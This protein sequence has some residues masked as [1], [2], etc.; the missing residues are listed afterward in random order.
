[1]GAVRIDSHQHFWRYRASDYPWIGP[2]MRVLARD[3]LPDALWPQMHAQALGASIAVQARA[4]RDETAFLLDLA[5]D[6]ARIAAVVGW[7]DLCSPQLGDHVAEWRSPKLRGFRH[8]L[9]DEAD[10]GAFVADPDFN[11]GIAWLQANGY[12]YDVL[13]FERQLADLRGFCARHDAHWLVLDHLG[14]PALAE[15]AHDA[16]AHA[17]WRT[18][19]RE[20]AALP[21]AMCKLSGLVTEADWKRGLR[22]QDIRHLEQCLDTALDAFGPQRLMFGSDWP[23]CL[24]AAS[25]DE[26]ASLVERWAEARLSAAERNALWGGTAA[27]CY[28]VPV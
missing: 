20:L 9:Q 4:G 12:V 5:R 17:R 13:V 21:H 18:A 15:F 26:V 19:L 27:R 28:G 24:L 1:M 22:A 23:V 16:G 2:D 14:K 7:E 25:Y 11:R 8:Q 10:V 6:D 3:Y